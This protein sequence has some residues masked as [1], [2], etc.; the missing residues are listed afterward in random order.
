MKTINEMLT[1]HPFFRDLP[2]QYIELMAGCG[3]NVH[4]KK[5]VYIIKEGDDADYFYLIRKG[6]VTL[7][8]YGAQRGPI[9]IQTMDEGDILGW[10][11]L[12]SPH[13][14]TSSAK[15]LEETSLIALDG[16]CLR[17]K[18]EKDHDL[19]YELFKRLS[20]VLTARLNWTRI[21]L[22]DLYGKP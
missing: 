22:L 16:K 8:I 14:W 13:K 4:F 20:P 18:C 15:A 21:Q 6:K 7:E 1:E 19:G 17:E 2:S 12:I 5:G 10:S 9:I 3:S 11:W